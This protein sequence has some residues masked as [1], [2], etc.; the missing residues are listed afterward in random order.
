MSKDKNKIKDIK[1]F[2][3]QFLSCLDLR[4]RDI[5]MSRYGLNNGEP[6]TL[7]AIG[8]KYKI[9][10]ERVR[11]IESVGLGIL[12]KSLDTPYLKTFIQTASLKLKEVG[13]VLREDQ[14]FADLKQS[15]KDNNDKAIFVNHARFLLELSKNFLNYRDKYDNDCHYHWHLSG[16]DKKKAYDFIAKFALELD[17]NRAHI[18]EN[19]AKFDE[20]FNSLVSEAKISP[21]VGRNYLSISKK[22]GSNPFN[23]K[24][25]NSW[26]EINPKTARDWAYVILKE[27]KKPLHFSELS[28]AIAEHRKDKETNLQ[29]VHNELIKDDRF[30]LVGRGLYGLKEFGLMPGTAKEIITYVLKN[31]GPMHSRDVI[32]FVKAERSFKDGTI[33]INLQNKNYFKSLS[34]GRYDLKEA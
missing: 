11:Q 5:I 31:N 16:K 22:F 7:Q 2:T 34:D 33:M 6:L 12:R 25:L 10:R 14:F 20:L 27:E 23:I 19:N 26:P 4:H 21:D 13:G 1:F 32:K 17:K 29:T 8:N 18:L 30:V 9:T 24:G 28:K 15:L 3:E